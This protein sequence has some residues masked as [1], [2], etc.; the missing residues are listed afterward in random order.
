M[1]PQAAAHKRGGTHRVREQDKTNTIFDEWDYKQLK[2]ECIERKI[3]VKDMKKVEMAKAL[4]ANEREKKR[5]EREAVIERENKQQ[6]L[7][8]EKRREE[9]RKMREAAAKTRRKIEKQAR[10]ERDESVSD[11]TPDEEELKVMHNELKGRDDEDPAQIQVGQALSED[12]WDSTSTETTSQTTDT[13]TVAGCRLQLFEWPYPTVPSPTIPSSQIPPARSPGGSILLRPEPRVPRRML[14]VPLK[15]HTTGTKEKMFLPG[16]TYPPGV[17][18]DYVPIL[19]PCV[20]RAVRNGH[21]TGI[22]RNA[23][24]EPA[25][26]WAKRT[27]IHGWNAHML[28]SLPSRSATTTLQAVYNKW[29]LEDRKLL[30]VKPTDSKADRDR[31]HAQR[32]A[33]KK[34]KVADVLDACQW[35][36]T[37]VC[38]LPAYLDY[39]EDPSPQGRTLENLW[40]VRFPGCDVPH[41]YFWSRRG[42]WDNPATPNPSWQGAQGQHDQLAD[43]E[44]DENDGIKLKDGTGV[45]QKRLPQPT[46]PPYRTLIRVATPWTPSPPPSLSSPPTVSDI[47]TRIEHELRTVG[48]A[49]T[50]T[51]YRSKW[52]D[53]GK[54]PAWTA[55]ARK[56]SLLYPSGNIPTTPP[57]NPAGAVSVAMKLASLD[58]LG[59]EA[60]LPPFKGDEPW[61]SNDDGRWEVVEVMAS[62]NDSEH[63]QTQASSRRGEVNALYRRSSIQLP[64]RLS[65]AA[66][67]AWLDTVSPS[68]APLSPGSVAASPE[69]E[70]SEAIREEWERQFLQPSPRGMNLKCPFC[71][72]PLGSMSFEAQAMHMYG[73]GTILPT[74]RR[75]SS[76]D[77]P[78]VALPTA[79]RRPSHLPLSRKYSVYDLGAEALPKTKSKKRKLNV[80]TGEMKRRRVSQQT[81]HLPFTPSTHIQSPYLPMFKRHPDGHPNAAWGPRKASQ[82]SMETLEYRDK[83]QHERTASRVLATED[84]D[85]E[86]GNSL[87]RL[88]ALDRRSSKTLDPSYSTLPT[89]R[90]DKDD[91][92]T[93]NERRS[94]DL[95]Y[96]DFSLGTHRRPEGQ[97]RSTFPARLIASQV[98]KKTTQADLD[99][100][101][102]NLPS[103]PPYEENGA[104]RPSTTSA[105]K[106]KRSTDPTYRDRPI[107][108]LD[109]GSPTVSSKPIKKRPKLADPTY[110]ACISSTSSESELGQPAP[111]SVLPP[112]RPTT[113][114]KRATQPNVRPEFASLHE[115]GDNVATKRVPL[116]RAQE[117]KTIITKRKKISDPTYR[118]YFSSMSDYE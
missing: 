27:S 22:L 5:R 107:L 108:A 34:R 18:P 78:R 4:A 15:V 88:Y 97:A 83:Y 41:Y 76:F 118:A 82:S 66:C 92:K 37:A 17:D 106:R 23:S 98:R 11:D 109:E 61:T 43:F 46:K 1:A 57:V 63:A 77:L 95:A 31:R 53:N 28:F 32:A 55:F 104:A 93:A 99:Y 94:V 40:Y 101:I 48:L 30:R 111:P 89:P 114:R 65:T 12:S 59:R 2:A 29:N 79:T 85:E 19:P 69:P 52:L 100:P 80:K 9:A 36:P 39:G 21:T 33:N 112:P 44:E 47:V 58:M 7:A 75:R 50:L 49:A 87:V 115:D 24:I 64:S 110:R 86:D 73:H 72:L 81:Y 8:K 117:A 13:Q 16:Q 3:Y 51:Y 71:L 10:R 14:Y 67:T 45:S 84:R 96:P 116:P 35:R 54:E 70:V 6:Q 56:L 38:Y 103:T 25:T 26:A 113:K 90:S 105:K 74:E 62:D 68:F 91:S 20:R 42:Q 102:L 60:L